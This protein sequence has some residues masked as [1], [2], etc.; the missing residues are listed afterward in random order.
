MSHGNKQEKLEQ[1]S[2]YFSI[3]P[4]PATHARLWFCVGWYELISNILFPTANIHVS[5]IGVHRQARD[6]VFTLWA[7]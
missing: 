5:Q 2:N 4:K 1:R 6:H 7:T 3:R